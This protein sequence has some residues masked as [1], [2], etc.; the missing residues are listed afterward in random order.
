MILIIFQKI[1][2]NFADEGA[3][4]F[5]GDGASERGA[6]LLRS[7]LKCNYKQAP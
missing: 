4:L 7:T 2:N 3:K 6:H 5:G 1:K